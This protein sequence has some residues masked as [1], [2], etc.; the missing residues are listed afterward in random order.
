MA[1]N[2]LRAVKVVDKKGVVAKASK[3]AKV[4]SKA[5]KAKKVDSRATVNSNA[6]SEVS[7]KGSPRIIHYDDGIHS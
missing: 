6:V 4:D 5:A 1:V 2:R 7:P 3:A